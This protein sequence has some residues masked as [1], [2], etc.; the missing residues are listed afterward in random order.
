MK[1]NTLSFAG[2]SSLTNAGYDDVLVLNAINAD[3]GSLKLVD[4]ESK[5][6]K[7]KCTKETKNK[8]SVF[9]LTVST[10]DKYEGTPTIALRFFE[11][12]ELVRDL[13]QKYGVKD[14]VYPIPTYFVEWLNK[15]AKKETKP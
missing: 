2:M 13:N 7:P 3:M 1:I 14:G 12:T 6:G 4:S 11:W 5:Y 15:F 10:G 8:V 9:K